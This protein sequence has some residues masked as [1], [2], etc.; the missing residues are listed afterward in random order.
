MLPLWPVHIYCVCILKIFHILTLL[1][2]ATFWL[3]WKL[4]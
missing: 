3:L 2:C 1:A 4:F